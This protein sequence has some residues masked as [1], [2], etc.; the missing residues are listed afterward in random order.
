MNIGVTLSDIVRVK[1]SELDEIVFGDLNDQDQFVVN[2]VSVT[3]PSSIATFRISFGGVIDY[4]SKKDLNF[5]GNNTY[6]NTIQAPAG[7]QLDGI[8]D[9]LTVKR[10][11][12]LSPTA[13]VQGFNLNTDADDVSITLGGLVPGSILV[14]DP[15]ALQGDGAWINSV[16]ADFGLEDAPID[17]RV[18]ARRDGLWKDIT[19]CIRCPEDDVSTIGPVTITKVTSGDIL[20]GKP[21][22]FNASSPG[23]A[24]DI[25]YTWSVVPNTVVIASVDNEKITIIFDEVIDYIVKVVANDFWATDSPQS[26]NYNVTVSETIGQVLITAE[27]NSVQVDVPILYSASFDGNVSNPN[28]TWSVSPNTASITVRDTNKASITFTDAIDYIVKCI[29]TSS[30]A[31]DSPQQGTYSVGVN[32]KIGNVTITKVTAGDIFVDAEVE[33]TSSHDGT[34]D[35]IS[36]EWFVDP[37]S[38]V[39]RNKNS[40]TVNITFNTATDYAVS[41]RLAS[42]TATDSPRSDTY[43]VGSSTEIGDVTVTKVTTGDILI[44]EEVEFTSSY[45]GTA[46]DVRYVWSTNPPTT[47]KNGTSSTAYITPTQATNYDVTCTLTSPIAADSPQSDTYS[48]DVGDTFRIHT[49]DNRDIKAEGGLNDGAFINYDNL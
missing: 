31:T 8:F 5:S 2:D 46:D 49:E 35:D 30:D 36:Y 1:I 23:D 20:V 9:D 17:G 22:T 7:K 27:S 14:W 3:D 18:Y 26:S 38:A 16:A 43:L 12:I 44:D 11:F 13:T 47:I 25:R 10:N 32:T 4:I 21:I 41:C 33:F 37:T 48:L 40:Q 34:A 28:Y 15:N 19:D 29:I 24:D 45:N 6:L 39:I 42:P